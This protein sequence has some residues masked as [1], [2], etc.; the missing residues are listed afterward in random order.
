[1][2]GRRFVVRYVAWA[3]A[4]AGAWWAG[5]RWLVPRLIESAYHE[6][7][8]GFLN[9]VV[10]GRD[11]HPL[12][13]YLEDWEALA[14]RVD[15]LL[16]AVVVLS[17]TVLYFRLPSRFRAAHRRLLEKADLASEPMSAGE[18]LLAAASGGLA[19]G[20]WTG[21]FLAYMSI[22]RGEAVPDFRFV[23]L[24]IVWMSPLADLFA[25]FVLGLV[26]IAVGS[27]ARRLRS[28]R[29]VIFVV[30]SC[31]LL[32]ALML[33]GWLHAWS[34][35]LLAL[36]V[37]YQGSRYAAI[38][39][40]P[41][42]A[43]GVALGLGALTVA[44]G[45]LVRSS[46]VASERAAFE[47]L[48]PIDASRPNVLL[49]VLDAVR[50]RSLSAYGHERR[51][52]PV[53]ERLAREGVVFDQAIATS[54]WSLPSHASMLTGRY[55]YELDTD[56]TVPL[57]DTYRT[58]A[59]ELRDRGY[60]TVASLGNLVFG[61]PLFGLDRGFVRYRA[62][63]LTPIEVL[64]SSLI[65]RR[66]VPWVMER[67]G[68]H[69]DISRKRASTVNSEILDWLDEAPD[70]PFFAFLNYFDAHGPYHAPAPFDRLFLEPPYRYW[71]GNEEPPEDRGLLKEL[72]AAYD[73]CIAYVDHQLGLLLEELAR[74]GRLENTL[75]I[76]TSDHG[77]A[78]LEHGAPA[79]ASGLH[80]EQ[81]R[82]P[83]LL[84]HP[85]RVPAGVRVSGPVSIRDIP[86]TV[87]DLLGF[88]EESPVFPG[89]PLAELWEG[90]EPESM[91]GEPVLSELNEDKSLVTERW[92]YI[93]KADGSEALFD[94]TNDPW[95][96]RDL[97]ESA[98][99]RAVLPKLRRKL[100]EVSGEPVPAPP[101]PA[102]SGP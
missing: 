101:A 76:V 37:A 3:V 66:V 54:S 21:A 57:N 14:G 41:R 63:P 2:R 91:R 102:G 53:L 5:S 87:M 31:T 26:L 22:V 36:G 75:V 43:G 72:E 25:F 89:R 68:F 4:L 96:Q 33:P 81:I 94:I 52:S 27:V 100:A 79:H 93:R 16:V 20:T 95:E 84:R 56:F 32:G 40:R 69:Q 99:G 65:S 86:A 42:V 55:N 59:E 90:E 92:H 49:V 80:L 71:W 11:V 46:A 35:A 29:W 64:R 85:G 23:S 18:T 24:D 45:G 58:L 39:W 38:L 83:L 44:A 28:R 12:D 61:H 9:R 30:L 97:S 67:L 78:F 73:S 13:R 70:R 47:A 10:S 34:A 17:F 98:A 6:R 62:Q 82:V 74:T 8:F 48:P 51:T 77:E 19:V 60:H 7:S 1:M 50:A 88:S 15:L